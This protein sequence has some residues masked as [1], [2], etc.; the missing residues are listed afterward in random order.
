MS[1]NRD[2]GKGVDDEEGQKL[3]DMKAKQEAEIEQAKDP[4]TP[5]KETAT[6]AKSRG[7]TRRPGKE[8]L[9]EDPTKIGE[10]EPR[11]I[12]LFEMQLT[13][14]DVEQDKLCIPVEFALDHFPPIP[15]LSPRCYEEK[16]NILSGTQDRVWPT[17]IRY[18]PDECVFL[19][20]SE[21]KGFAQSHEMKAKDV[22]RFYTPLPCS[23]DKQYMLIDHVKRNPQDD[24]VIRHLDCT[25]KYFIFHHQLTY[26]DLNFGLLLS[27]VEVRN[28]FRVVGIPAETHNV[29]RL[30][31]T[32]A[33]NTDWCMKITMFNDWYTINGP[34]WDQCVKDYHLEPG[35]FISFYRCV[36]PFNS[37]H[38]LIRLQKLVKEFKGG[39]GK[40][41][42]KPQGD[43]GSS[44]ENKSRFA[45]CCIA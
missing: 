23:P 16:V 10:S 4:S 18:D 7:S 39:D 15:T 26:F 32:D 5:L 17:T 29:E 3:E 31:F 13:E 11:R 34:G 40:G 2:N 24:A 27:K 44:K 43:G 21:W 14:S 9:E 41:G 20:N 12:F 30:Y 36:Q 19:L 6:D 38:F 8:I 33:K 1:E 22:V 28:H 45:H 25:S 35:D 37:R 42:D